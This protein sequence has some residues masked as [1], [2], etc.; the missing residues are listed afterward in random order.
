[1][2]EHF[3]PNYDSWYKTSNLRHPIQD[4]RPN[5]PDLFW[6][7]GLYADGSVIRFILY[8]YLVVSQNLA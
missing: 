8:V 4:T 6:Y 1:M 2:A 7:N 5:T 3:L